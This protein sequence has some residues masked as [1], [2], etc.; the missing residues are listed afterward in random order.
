MSPKT[1]RVVL[2]ARKAYRATKQFEVDQLMADQSYWMRKRTIAN[3]KL[4]YVR[5]Q[6]DAITKELSKPKEGGD[7]K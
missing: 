7:A 2:E 3:N 6:L 5:R 4:E 1:E